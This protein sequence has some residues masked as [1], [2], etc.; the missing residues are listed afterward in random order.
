MANPASIETLLEL[1]NR[2]ADEA[3]ERLGAALRAA[4]EADDKFN[5]LVQYRNDYAER[6]QANLE[7]GLSSSTYSNYRSFMLK[8]DQAISGQL[9][10]VRS[11]RKRSDDAHAF[12]MA[13]EQ[14][15]MSYGKL[16][17]RAHA[18]VQRKEA[19]RDQKLNDEH[20]SRLMFKR[21]HSGIQ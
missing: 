9:E 14:K 15:K 21:K 10:V 20:A 17:S 18:E 7:N 13:C 4:T 19:R 2:E 12:L 8:L 16:A 3:S 5:M 11:C 1:A 6:C